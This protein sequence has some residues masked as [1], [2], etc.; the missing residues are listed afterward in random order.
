MQGPFTY[1]LPDE[2]FST[3][4]FGS[5]L[6]LMIFPVFPSPVL[7]PLHTLPTP[8]FELSDLKRP[9]QNAARKHAT[10]RIPVI[11]RVH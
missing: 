2:E 3:G 4:C 7:G 8:K 1:R 11:C 6:T 10:R 9:T 5:H